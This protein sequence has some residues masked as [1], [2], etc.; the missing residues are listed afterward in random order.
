[1]CSLLA[2]FGLN[3]P[4]LH[5]K[6][7]ASCAYICRGRRNCNFVLRFVTCVTSFAQRISLVL[8]PSK[9]KTHDNDAFIYVF[10]AL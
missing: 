3:S 2:Q 6:F 5:W 7:S 10:P 4:Q 1:M 9:P 8:W